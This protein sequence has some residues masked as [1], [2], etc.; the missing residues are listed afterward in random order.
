MRNRPSSQA[1]SSE[2]HKV[3]VRLRPAEAADVDFLLALAAD[4]EIEPFMGVLGVRERDDLLRRIERGRAEPERSGRM[5]IEHDGTA[6]GALAYDLTP[7]GSPPSVILHAVM[8]D[9]AARGRGVAREAVRLA[10]RHLIRD[11]G[12]HRVQLECY[13]FNERAIRLFER[14]G[15]V[16]EGVKREAYHRH[17]AWEDGVMFGLIED[18]L[19]S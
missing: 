15:Y 6:V 2:P 7:G 12:H 18:D 13:G 17:G 1:C 4:P 8:L 10:G 9:P 16:R 3:E 5:V 19:S 14:A 11:L